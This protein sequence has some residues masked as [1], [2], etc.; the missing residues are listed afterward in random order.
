[1]VNN[2]ILFSG[3]LF[4]NMNESCYKIKNENKWF[5]PND[6]YGLIIRQAGRERETR[7]TFL[8]VCFETTNLEILYRICLKSIKRES[9]WNIVSKQ[10]DFLFM[11]RN[12]KIKFFFVSLPNSGYEVKKLFRPLWTAHDKK[13][14]IRLA[15]SMTNRGLKVF[16]DFSWFLLWK[17]GKS[18]KMCL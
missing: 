8:R 15:K 6:A 5:V 2:E 13:R 4:R 9:F 14:L 16:H 1:M 12:V 7:N 18:L 17:S 11:F 3:S 10:S